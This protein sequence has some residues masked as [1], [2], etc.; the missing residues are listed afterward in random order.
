MT[1]G[2]SISDYWDIVLAAAADD[3]GRPL[4]HMEDQYICSIQNTVLKFN[5][6]KK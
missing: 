2:F 1:L 6:V 3:E 4:T 5:S